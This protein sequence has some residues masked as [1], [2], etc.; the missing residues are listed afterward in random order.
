MDSPSIPS[1]TG[2]DRHQHMQQ[3]GSRRRAEHIGGRPRLCRAKR[4]VRHPHELLA[5]VD[6]HCSVDET[7]ESN[8]A[9]TKI[10]DVG[11]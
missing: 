7:K 4:G 9:R 1:C 2:A 11:F 8:N 6:A 5:Y 3:T 10:I